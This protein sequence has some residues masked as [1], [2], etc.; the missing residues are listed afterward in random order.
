MIGHSNG[1]HVA[2]AAESHDSLAVLRRLF[3]VSVVEFA[4]GARNRA[5]ILLHERKSFRLVELARD[6]EHHIIRLIKLLIERAEVVDRH[7]FNIAP[8]ADG[9]FAVVMPLIGGGTDALV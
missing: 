6:D 9:R 2:D 1:G 5:K 3:S 4:F 8:V 7:P